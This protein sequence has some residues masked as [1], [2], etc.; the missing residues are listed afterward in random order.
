MA[1]LMAA[2]CIS[3]CTAQK[4]EY[5]SAELFGGRDGY[6]MGKAQILQNIKEY[7]DHV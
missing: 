3:G 5:V 2:V 1:V 7:Y 6:L 4:K